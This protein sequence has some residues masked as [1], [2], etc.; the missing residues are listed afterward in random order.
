[1]AVGDDRQHGCNDGYDD[2]PDV[3]YTWDDTVP[4]HAK[5]QVGDR[6]AIWD[7]RTILGVSVIEHISIED[8][9]EKLVHRCPVCE[10]AN[11]KARKKKSPRY[12]CFKCAAEFDIPKSLVS[13]T[14]RYRSRHDACWVDLY[15]ALT[16][17]RIRNLCASPESQLSLRRM[18]WDSLMVAIEGHPRSKEAGAWTTERVPQFGGGHQRR[19]TRVRVGQASFRA[20]TLARYGPV[21]AISGIAPPEVLDAAHLYSY[22]EVGT[23]YE[24][25]G[26][27]LRKD[28]HLLFDRGIICIDPDTLEIDVS[29]AVR[30][31][32]SYEVF[33]RSRVQIPINDA[34]QSWIA[35][36]WTQHRE[37]AVVGNSVS[38]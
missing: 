33:H 16:R 13:R 5:L 22:A 6:I 11:L 32:G 26:I 30:G 7:K 10:R 35:T 38:V 1:M 4:N 15:G 8:D 2:D 24:H 25:G 29:P 36:H 21:C 3:S 12:R 9:V 31:Y 34:Q 18:N 14:R 37:L 20:R 17:D 27:L 23:H 28:I 19:L